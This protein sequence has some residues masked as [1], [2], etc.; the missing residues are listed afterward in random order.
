[1]IHSQRDMWKNQRRKLTGSV[2]SNLLVLILN[3]CSNFETL[4]HLLKGC[5]GSGV[6]SMP[7]AFAHAGLWFGLIATAIIGIICTYCVHELVSSAHLL[8][9]RV[10]IPSLRFSQIAEVAFETGPERVQKYAKTAGF[11]IDLFLC[12]DLIGACCVYNV[13][14]AKNLK[15]VIE[16]YH[17]VD[18]NIRLY[19]CML[20][21]PLLIVNSIRLLKVLAPFSLLANILMIGGIGITLSYIFKD[22]PSTSIRPFAVEFTKWPMFFGNVIFALE[23]I[24]VVMS[25]ENNMK[26]PAR[27]IG[28]AGILNIAM[29]C[30]VLLYSIVGFFGYL[31]YGGD[32][33]GS[34]TLNIPTNE[35]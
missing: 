35:K 11:L 4:V 23:G 15:Q 14:V 26:H 1:M 3:V 30:V 5:I 32:I 21:I 18:I 12:L 27:F 33:K 34:I 24:A 9:H 13:F 7:F 6:L 22:L 17:D 28:K 29:V 2:F 25:L 31:K 8:S 10:K 16:N 19:I 20:L